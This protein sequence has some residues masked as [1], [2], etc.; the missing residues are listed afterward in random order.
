[1]QRS[2]PREWLGDVGCAMR[3]VRC[4]MCDAGCAMR[5]VRGGMCVRCFTSRL[6]HE[7][8]QGVDC[9]LRIGWMGG[10]T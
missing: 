2:R 9:D 6:G 3:D 10:R 5:D 8:R 4:G 1:M 7:G